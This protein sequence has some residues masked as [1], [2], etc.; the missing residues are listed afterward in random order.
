MPGRMENLILIGIIE[1][2]IKN[3]GNY[4]KAVDN[5]KLIVSA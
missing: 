3:A 2:F 5:V 4:Y 1:I